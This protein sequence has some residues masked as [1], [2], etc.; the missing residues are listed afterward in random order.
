MRPGL[1][2][3]ALLAAA[4]DPAPAKADY[5]PGGLYSVTDGKS[6][7]VVKVLASDAAA[8]HVRLYKNSWPARPAR[9]DPATLQLG[10][11]S[12]EDGFGVGH[13][14]LDRETFAGWEP[15]FLAATTLSPG[16]LEGV[17]TK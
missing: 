6:F 17:S 11:L 15:V 9:V 13:L 16:E 5:V 10:S 12:D 1:A 7:K 2:L 8:V 3:V 14:P 4:C